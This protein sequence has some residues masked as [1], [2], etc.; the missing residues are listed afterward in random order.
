M[1]L[2][3]KE[4]T[5]VIYNLIGPQSCVLAVNKIAIKILW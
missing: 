5:F 3:F 1:R 2:R 4:K